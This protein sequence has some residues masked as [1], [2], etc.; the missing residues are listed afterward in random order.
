MGEVLR[1]LHL[2]DSPI[3]AEL[4]EATLAADGLD[5]ELARVESR[6]DFLAAI[7]QVGFEL[8]LADYSLPAFDGLSA[9]ALAREL[10]P[11][12][13][14]IFV[15]GALGEE[16]A[17]ETLKSGA[18]D[19]VLKTRL[20]RLAP[21]VRRALRETQERVERCRAEEQLS[22]SERR[23]RELAEHIR[24]VFWMTDRRRPEVIYVSP[25]Y[26]EVWGRT[27]QSLYEHPDSFLEAIHPDDRDR[28]RNA[29]ARQLRGEQT[30]DEYR[31]IRPDGAV[32]WIW[33]RGFPIRDAAGQV[34]RVAGIAE[35]ITERKQ[36]E[37]GQ[38]LLAEAGIVLANA[39]EYEALAQGLA[40][41]VVPR[42][43]D[44]CT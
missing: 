34:S 7:R 28:V 29:I 11:D 24:Q 9:L 18:T 17:I 26:E 31:I 36:A 10:C 42:L 6:A 15:S 41:L 12:V 37:L 43:A 23:F 8:I 40:R 33:D 35:D 2:E 44:W 25:A 27:C 20:K 38:R 5:C 22:Q 4:I 3:D 1:I 19:Y 39:L 30:E 16:M 32:R 14:F 13:P 21:A